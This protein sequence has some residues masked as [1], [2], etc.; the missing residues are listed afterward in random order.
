MPNYNV[1]YARPAKSLLKLRDELN[2]VWPGRFTGTDGFLTGYGQ[3]QLT[4]HNPNHLGHVMAFDISTAIGQNIDEPTGRALAEYLRS[5]ANI[6]FRYL[7]HDMSEGAPAPKIA[8]D[9]D[10]WAWA[11]YVGD[12]HSNHIHVSLTDDYLWG[13]DCGLAQE[14]YDDESSWGIA[15]FFAGAP[16]AVV[17]PQGGVT[18][19]PI[20]PAPAVD[21]TFLA[22][23]E[24]GDTLTSIANQFSVTVDQIVAVNPG[25]NPN[26]IYPNQTL[27]IPGTFPG[28]GAHSAAA[29]AAASAASASP[30]PV[31]AA[32]VN[33][34]VT[35]AVAYARTSPSAS[36]PLAPGYPEGIAQGAQLAVVGYVAGEDPYGTGDNAWYVTTG[37]YYVWANAASNDLT[38]LPSL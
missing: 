9:F 28:E 5:Q 12:N 23:V 19:P 11:D 33:R 16:V 34:L 14:I 36:A 22:N 15:E 21:G 31:P 18:S 27:N 30:T 10:G 20:A 38:G 8:G 25:L 1:T 29:A 26:L 13:D 7:I 24:T 35:N 6:K 4:G 17:A 3:G 37:G 32:A 2:A